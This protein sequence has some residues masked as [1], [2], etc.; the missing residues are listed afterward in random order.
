MGTIADI[1]LFLAFVCILVYI[2]YFPY[3]FS[4]LFYIGIVHWY[5]PYNLI[6]RLQN[7]WVEFDQL[8]QKLTSSRDEYGGCWAL[9]LLFWVTLSSSV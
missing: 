6:L 9:S 2:N 1:I 3:S 8:K 4:P 7:M 5:K